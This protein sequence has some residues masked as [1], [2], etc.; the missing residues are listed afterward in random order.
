M[1]TIGNRSVQ[2]LVVGAGPV[3]LFAGLSAARAGLEVEVIDQSFRGFGRGYATLL[4]PSSVRLLGEVGVLGPLQKVGREIHGV[5]LR[6]GDGPR[7]HVRLAA[8][9][10]CVPQSALEGALLAA[11]R[12]AGVEVN[13][14]CEATTIKQ[15]GAKVELRIVR[16]ELETPGSSSEDSDW[17]AVDSSIVVAD[18]VLGADGYDSRVRT[19][20]GID[21]VTLGGTETFAMFEAPTQVGSSSDIEIAFSDEVATS[22]VPLANERAR[23]GF[24]LTSRL[25][26]EPDAHRLQE[27]LVERAPWFQDRPSRVDWGSVVHFERRLVR[28]FGNG[29]VWLAG[30][31]AHVTNP[32]GAQSMNVGLSE[33][34]DFV[35]RVAACTRGDSAV[36]S[37]S[38]Y[39]AMSE[40]VWHKLFGYNVKFDVLS[41]APPWLASHAR[42]VSP[43][44]PASGADLRDAL[45][46]LG[47]ALT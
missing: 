20:L 3:G 28:R 13:A 29:R 23:F 44:L 36:E 45:Q 32:F 22:I 16:R 41:H 11:V 10:L 21:T 31:A 34:N 33:A 18:Y 17:Q 2:L 5:G 8:P 6:V 12:E 38:E 47:L 9:A 37:L 7:A 19:A 43:T 1:T 27:L 24:Q 42:S 40:R 15:V 46:Q 4:H 39:G 35:R 25:D 30:D 26:A 14:P